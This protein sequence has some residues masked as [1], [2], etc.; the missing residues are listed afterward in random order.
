MKAWAQ[1]RSPLMIAS[2]TSGTADPPAP[3]VL[4]CIPLSVRD[5]CNQTQQELARDGGGSLL[6]QFDEGKFRGAVNGNE[7]VQLALFGPHLGYIDVE[8]AIG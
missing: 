8:I 1:K 7:H 4:N 2:L 5:G 6:V 3:G